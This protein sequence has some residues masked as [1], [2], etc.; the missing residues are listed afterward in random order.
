MQR[1]PLDADNRDTSVHR[2]IYRIFGSAFFSVEN[3]DNSGGVIDHPLISDL[4]AGSAVALTD[5][6]HEVCGCQYLFVLSLPFLSPTA[7]KAVIGASTHQF[8]IAPLIA[9][10][11]NDLCRPDVHSS[12]H[13][14]Y[15]DIQPVSDSLADFFFQILR[16]GFLVPCQLFGAMTR[17]AHPVQ[18]FFS[19]GHNSPTVFLFY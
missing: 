1:S 18:S 12:C 11:Q 17:K 5:I 3:G 13:S 4:E 16:D 6:F 10:H 8:D 14:R 9:E 7:L 19:F 2:I 15:K